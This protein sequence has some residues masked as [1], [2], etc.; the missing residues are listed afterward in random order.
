MIYVGREFGTHPWIYNLMVESIHGCIKN[1]SFYTKT[2]GTKE[3]NMMT[4][5][6]NAAAFFV[7]RQT[8]LVFLM[9][10]LL[11][12]VSGLLSPAFAVPI[13]DQSNTYPSSGGISTYTIYETPEN[14]YVLAQT[15]TAGISGQLVAVNL[16]LVDKAY[17]DLT[18][19]IVE[20]SSGGLP[21]FSGTPLATGT[22]TPDDVDW[23]SFSLE[24]VDLSSFMLNITASEMYAIVLS[25][26]TPLQHEYDWTRG[27][28]DP[29]TGDDLSALDPYAG[30]AG[31]FSDDGGATWSPLT[32]YS[33]DF[34]FQTIVDPNPVP[35]PGTF[36]L[37]I[38][39][40]SGFSAF[41]RRA[42]I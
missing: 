33:Q 9:I 17:E 15:F 26:S 27:S 4:V 1:L 3:K 14:Q 12:T 13:V 38:A 22:L 35:E 29:Y 21:E 25:S 11:M 34:S 30:G 20:T 32:S 23:D 39:G 28:F 6:K 19:S 37:L 5:K 2:Y 24:T 7:N 31:Y 18:I 16:G 8:F 36:M 41:R 40:I 10:V 42:K